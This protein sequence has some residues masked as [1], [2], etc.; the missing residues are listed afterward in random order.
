[1]KRLAVVVRR[2]S[3]ILVRLRSAV[4]HVR[5]RVAGLRVGGLLVHAAAVERRHRLGDDELL[6]GKLRRKIGPGLVMIVVAQQVEGAGVKYRIG[7]T[8]V[9]ARRRNGSRDRKSVV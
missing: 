1:P 7:R 3:V 4:L 2:E 6:P 9:V 5:R 8:A